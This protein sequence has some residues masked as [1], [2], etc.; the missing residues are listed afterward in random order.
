[1][2]DIDS[3]D[4]DALIVSTR[5]DLAGFPVDDP[6]HEIVLNK[7]ERLSAI[8][9]AN[10]KTATEAQLTL[11]EARQKTEDG[12]TKRSLMANPPIDRNVLISAGSS[13]AGILL[14]VSAERTAVVASK[15]L[16]FVGRSMTRIV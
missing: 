5:E 13:L 15:A 1:M 8:Q 4:L 12:K 16:G 9:R 7:L 2:S 10:I 3:L 6:R 11:E 14:I